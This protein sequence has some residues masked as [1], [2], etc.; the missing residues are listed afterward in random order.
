MF[1]VYTSH[2]M[3]NFSAVEPIILAKTL[4]KFE[5]KNYCL[6]YKAF[7]FPDGFAGFMYGSIIG[8]HHDNYIINKSALDKILRMFIERSLSSIGHILIVVTHRKPSFALLIMAAEF[9]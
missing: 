4:V 3:P 2:N 6:A 1:L 5:I 7:S 8:R 9:Q